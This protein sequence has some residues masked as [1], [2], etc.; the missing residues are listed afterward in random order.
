M[1]NCELIS[2]RQKDLKQIAA[3]WNETLLY[4]PVSEDR[5]FQQVVM[6]E[7]FDGDLAL[8]LEKDGC[9]IGFCLG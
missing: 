9:I 8:S 5:F 1:G 2:Y 6:D 4:D 3:G 7:N